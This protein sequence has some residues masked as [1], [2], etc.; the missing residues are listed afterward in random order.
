MCRDA[1]YRDVKIC[2]NLNET[3]IHPSGM[4]LNVK[5]PIY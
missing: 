5:T 3:H 1:F 4:G 2:K